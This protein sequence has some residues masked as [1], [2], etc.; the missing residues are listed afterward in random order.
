M[1]FKC[2]R[3]QRLID[4]LSVFAVCYGS[5]PFQ[6]RL[7][8]IAVSETS[9]NSRVEFSLRNERMLLVFPIY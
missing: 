7:W 6:K 9:L 4:M 5:N 2:L 3:V 8:L 1:P